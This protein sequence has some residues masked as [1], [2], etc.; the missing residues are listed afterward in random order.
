M[1]EKELRK[2][3]VET[4]LARAEKEL[5]GHYEIGGILRNAQDKVG[6]RVAEQWIEEHMLEVLKRI[7]LD[8][9]IKLATLKIIEKIA[10]KLSER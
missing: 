8:A 6:A 7:D 9:V 3:I 5:L 10:T 1:D 4:A 2:E